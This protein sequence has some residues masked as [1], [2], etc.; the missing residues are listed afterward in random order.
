MTHRE[1]CVWLYGY[2]EI[3]TSNANTKLYPP[4]TKLVRER[5]RAVLGDDIDPHTRPRLIR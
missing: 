4:Q 3:A 2:L 5:L 1:F